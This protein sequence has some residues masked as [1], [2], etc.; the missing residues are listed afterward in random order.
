MGTLERPVDRGTRLGRASLARVGQEIRDARLGRG[1][2]LAAAAR[3]AGVSRSAL[4][5]IELGQAPMVPLLTLSRCAA[6]VGLDLSTRASP[7]GRPFRDAAQLTLLKQVRDEL[8]PS[9]AWATE[10]ALPV[11]GDQRAWDA[12][13]RGDGWTFGVEAET[14]PRDAQAT[15]RRIHLK[16]RDS[17]LDGAVLVVRDTRRSRTFLRDE[18]EA[19]QSIFPAPGR[20][21]LADLRAGRRPED[22]A[23]ILLSLQPLARPFP[24]PPGPPVP[25]PPPF[26]PGGTGRPARARHP[27]GGGPRSPIGP[28]LVGIPRRA[29]SVDAVWVSWAA[30][31]RFE[32]GRAGI[33]VVLSRGTGMG[34]GTERARATPTGPGTER[35]GSARRRLARARTATGPG[36]RAG[37]GLRDVVAR[38]E[39]A[40]EPLYSR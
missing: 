7:G 17:G 14:M 2:S 25:A 10:V 4:G 11:A 28:N 36:R 19:L 30:W 31:L 26:P 38:R 9:L 1:L 24:T 21:A 33:G 37:P 22:N 32:F 20:R 34:P 12:T 3:A 8:P 16:L 27:A 29:G 18:A 35:A 5:R 23:I 13:I 39:S 6:V 40:A 15:A